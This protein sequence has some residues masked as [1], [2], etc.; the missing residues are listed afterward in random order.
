MYI[1]RTD[2]RRVDQQEQK[3][4]EA[5]LVSLLRSLYSYLLL[6]PLWS[7]SFYESR[8]CRQCGIVGT[9]NSTHYHTS[10]HVYSFY[11]HLLRRRVMYE[12]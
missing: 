2:H 4:K 1:M 12:N 9:G 5:A 3:R 6:L 8:L 10:D 7:K 11:H